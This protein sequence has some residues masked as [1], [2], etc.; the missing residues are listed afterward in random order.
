MEKLPEGISFH[1]PPLP[2]TPMR[3]NHLVGNEKFLV[4]A[5]WK[6]MHDTE[7]Q[8]ISIYLRSLLRIRQDLVRLV[9]TSVQ[10]YGAT[11]SLSQMH[12]TN[13]FEFTI[14]VGANLIET[15]ARKPVAVRRSMAHLIDNW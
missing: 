10:V 3:F 1:S 12:V 8:K 14:F 15:E 13:F 9:I 6:K 2:P 11:Y 4:S 7:Q 5:L